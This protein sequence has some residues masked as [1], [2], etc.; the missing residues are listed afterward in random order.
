LKNIPIV[1]LQLSRLCAQSTS[2]HHV[3]LKLSSQGKKIPNSIV[4][5]K[6]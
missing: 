2:T 3:S 4:L 5:L 1:D 6:Y